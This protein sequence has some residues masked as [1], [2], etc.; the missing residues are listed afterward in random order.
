M[1]TWTPAIGLGLKAYLHRRTAKLSCCKRSAIDAR[2]TQLDQLRGLLTVARNTEIGRTA[3]FD[4]LLARSDRDLLPAYQDSIKSADYEAHR[5]SYARMREDA[6][7]DVMWPGVVRH[8]AQTSGTTGGEKYIPVTEQ[9]FRSNRI[10]ALDIFVHATRM[11]ASLP[12]IFGGKLLFLGGSTELAVNEKGIATGD[13]SGLVTP[14][15]R[16]PLS[17]VYTPGPEI[18]LLSHWP[19]KLDRII[20]LTIKQDVRF[21]SGMASWSLTLYER[22][23]E[24]ARSRGLIAKDAHLNALWPNLSLY[25]HG[26]VRYPPFDPRV[27]K[28]WSGSD[29]ITDPSADIPHRVEVY[30]ASEGFIA[31]QDTQGDPGL[32]LSTD[33][34]LFF[35]F[36]PVEEMG[37]EHPRAFMCDEVE[38]GQR[39]VVVMSTCAGMWRYIIG[40]VVEFDTIPPNGPPRLRIVGR[41]RHFINAFGE[42]LIVEEVESAVVAAAREVGLTIGEFTACPVYPTPTTRSGLELVYETTDPGAD[43]V[44][45]R[46]AVDRAL[47]A[48]NVDYTTK[49]GESVG[50]VEPTMTPMPMGAFDAWMES[51]GKLGGQHK[52]PRCANHRDFVEGLR[53][54]LHAGA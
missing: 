33:V 27:R 5:A 19:T 32:R 47:M 9:M 45:F 40:D 51:R 16:W 22:L 15:I 52:V 35:E 11:G 10:A 49:R 28:V 38:P 42:N 29:D 3:R 30:P 13:L 39:Y 17:A 1:A 18:A 53:G 31:M 24:A 46:D 50:M 6:Q 23:V 36:I 25:V 48:R 37:N 44:A 20:E 34:G 7:P 8:W 41:H 2:A 21:V 54:M 43:T 26:G 14:L 4:K 12:Q